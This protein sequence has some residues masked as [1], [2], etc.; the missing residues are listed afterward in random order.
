MPRRVEYFPPTIDHIREAAVRIAPFIHRTPVLTSRGIDALTNSELFFKCENFQRAG[1]F[2]MRGASNAIAQLSPEERGRG[3]A[4]HSSGNH[5]AA[6]ALA[7]RTMGLKAWVVMPE[8]APRVKRD[9]VASYGAEI[10]Y[11]APNLKAREETLREVVETTGAAVVHP[12]DDDRVIAGQGTAALELVE[13][14]EALDFVLVPVGGG[15]LS[16]GTSIAVRA[17]SPKT[18]VIGVE[19]EGADDAC[20]S[21]EAGRI[22]PIEAPRSIADGLLATLSERTFRILRDFSDGIVTVSDDYIREA[23]R[24]IAERMKIV[25]E[26]SAAVPLAAILAGRVDVAGKRAGIILTGG[27]LDP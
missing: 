19:P 8:T 12:Y 20:R 6:V 7:A 4:T 9:A 17:L 25:V 1:A 27:N 26:P 14:A 5:G 22:V 3:V 10:R 18:R 23:M 15:G 21:L 11:C 13:D 24:L 16:S 2:K